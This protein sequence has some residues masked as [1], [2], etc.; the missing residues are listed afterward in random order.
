MKVQGKLWKELM[1]FPIYLVGMLAFALITA[2]S[3]IYQS[4]WT[5]IIVDR[6]VF[7]N[8]AIDALLPAFKTLIV[9]IVLRGLIQF[10]FQ[11]TA[12]QAGSRIIHRMRVNSL[13]NLLPVI[14]ERRGDLSSGRISTL[15]TDKLDAIK[16]YYSQ[17]I[18]QMML[19]ALIPITVLVFIFPLDWVSG[20][21]FILTAPLI[22]LFMALIGS[23]SK[24][25]TEYRW[26]YLSRLADHFAD[27]IRGMEVLK[28]FNQAKQRL[29]D[30][31]HVSTRYATLTMDILKITFLSALAL[32]LLTT[33]S[34]AVVAVEIGLRLLHSGIDFQTAFFI[35]LIA[36]E[37]YLPLR[38]LG[39]K[40]HAG[41][42]GQTAA[43]EFFEL[44]A[45]TV[46]EPV[47]GLNSGLISQEGTSIAFENVSFQYAEG[48]DE[49]L[50]DISF[51]CSPGTV[52]ALIGRSGSGK[53]TIAKLA[54]RFIEP[55]NGRVLMN[56]VPA[57]EISKSQ[58]YAQIAW[59]G[60]KSFY[61]EGTILDNLRFANQA[62]NE[63]VIIDALDRV[64]L[65]EKVDSLPDGLLTSIAEFGQ[66]FSGGE[67]QRLQIARAL[68]S[69][70]PLLILDEPTSQ[71]DPDLEALFI[72]E[73]E[74]IRR[75]KTVLLIAH[76]LQTVKHADTI[77]F[78]EAGHIVEQGTHE[79]LLRQ[80]GRYLKMTQLYQAGGRV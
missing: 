68:I 43:I 15:F 6:A 70:A 23:Q 36:P 45:A 57:G 35:L 77:L 8:A 22:P 54:L 31:E 53:S 24:K 61:A 48:K 52:T 79:K 42:T 65:I 34:T 13:E 12:N 64:G 80:A 17:Y 69:D 21:V 49:V 18:A 32:E 14:A 62:A 51:T 76:R 27:H 55:E 28:Q 63:K 3:I 20:L 72:A 59:L 30:I 74:N 29:S 50:H 44:F 41:M 7:E 16:Q 71:L 67:V 60:Q 37:F 56:G 10:L 73:L 11:W 40:F 75:N 33:L 46:L 1:Q 4:K 5:S 9:F 2:I 58:W 78:L 19:S 25:A 38:M 66:N 26:G 47:S 39:L